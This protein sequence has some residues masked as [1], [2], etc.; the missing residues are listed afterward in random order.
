MIPLLEGSL[1][2]DSSSV[3]LRKKKSVIY[4]KTYI[5]QH[6]DL[7]VKILFAIIDSVNF[8]YLVFDPTYK[9][10]NMKYILDC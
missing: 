6:F 1:C 3:L 9:S 4:I 5:T 10:Q 7:K 8:S 2:S